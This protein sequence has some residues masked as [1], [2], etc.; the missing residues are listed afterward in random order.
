MII[1]NRGG[2]NCEPLY[3]V[4]FNK[5]KH[6]LCV[7]CSEIDFSGTRKCTQEEFKKIENI[8]NEM[9]EVQQKYN[10]L[11]EKL[12]EALDVDIDDDG[13]YDADY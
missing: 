9:I 6:E 10:T 11:N 2:E 13:V 8:Y 12:W 4:K 3:E 1:E 7:N 5:K